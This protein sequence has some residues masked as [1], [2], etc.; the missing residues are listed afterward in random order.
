[1]PDDFYNEFNKPFKT[2]QAIL[3]KINEKKKLNPL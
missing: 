2:A 1:M 3:N